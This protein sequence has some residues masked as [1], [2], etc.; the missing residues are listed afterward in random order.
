[1]SNIGKEYIKIPQKVKIFIEK[2]FITVEGP[3]GKLKK[4]LPKNIIIIHKNDKIYFLP[5]DF[6]N[7]NV[8]KIQFGVL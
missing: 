2:D 4:S 3:L 8:E 5:N 6:F 1:M 7:L